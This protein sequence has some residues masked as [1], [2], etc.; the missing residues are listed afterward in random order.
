MSQTVTCTQLGKY[1]PQ[2]KITFDSMLDSVKILSS[3]GVPKGKVFVI[4]ED[5]FWGKGWFE[6][7]FDKFNKRT[8]KDWVWCGFT[9]LR[10]ETI[11]KIRKC[12]KLSLAKKKA[13]LVKRFNRG[14]VNL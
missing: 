2:E 8:L 7:A 1:H 12:R 11:H 9:R 13:F 10:P 3:A 4:N 6:D 14:F 5:E